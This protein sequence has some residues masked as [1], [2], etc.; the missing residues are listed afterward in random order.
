M[1]TNVR[2][3]GFSLTVAAFLVA[4][5]VLFHFGSQ[6]TAPPARER[7]PS[8]PLSSLH[9]SPLKSGEEFGPGYATLT[10]HSIPADAWVTVDG[11]TLGA[12]PIERHRVPIGVYIISVSKGGYFGRD[13]LMVL[14]TNQSAVY[15][16]QLKRS[17]G[18]MAT[19]TTSWQEVLRVIEERTSL[20][21]S[22]DDSSKDD[23]TSPLVRDTT[24][25]VHSVPD[26]H[27]PDFGNV[28][29]SSTPEQAAV[30]VDGIHV[31]RTPLRIDWL[32]VGVYDIEVSHPGHDTIFTRMEVVPKTDRTVDVTL[33]RQRG[34]LR[35]LVHPW[36][37]LYI[38]GKLHRQ[39]LDVWYETSLPTGTHEVTAVHPQLGRQ[40]QRVVVKDN[41]TQR[42][43]FDFQKNENTD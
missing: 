17:Y 16:P 31:G 5:G 36:G 27:F 43:V 2:R 9:S 11:D 39:E 25:S 35:I 41:Q 42:L 28:R 20:S 14:R 26:I 32:P 21:P 12:T 30:K 6:I 37:A 24:N 29:I 38:D 4:I 1:L 3:Y 7:A 8:T 34:R 18:L 19:Q 22:K 13:T 23:L 15:A 33:T 10:V 40:T